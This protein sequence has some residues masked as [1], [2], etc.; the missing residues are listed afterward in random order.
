VGREVVEAAVRSRSAS[1]QL[2]IADQAVSAGEEMTRLAGERQASEVGVVLE[3]VMARE[4][5]TRAR[6]GR[7]R[8]VVDFNRAQYA[9]KMAVGISAVPDAAA[10]TGVHLR[11]A[12]PGVR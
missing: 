9:L 3:Y 2:A 7:V 8:A 5:L 11:S 1:E 4:D 12:A 6:L 10:R